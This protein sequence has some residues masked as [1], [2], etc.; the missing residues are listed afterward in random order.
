MGPLSSGRPQGYSL[1]HR[2]GRV[3]GP[4]GLQG[5]AK[6]PNRA[7]LQELIGDGVPISKGMGA[8]HDADTFRKI[9]EPQSPEP[10]AGL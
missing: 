7:V 6:V 2:E 1:Y 10:W 8:Y 9:F 5:L 4:R 3:A